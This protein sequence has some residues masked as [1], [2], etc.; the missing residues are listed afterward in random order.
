M[1]I[2]VSHLIY[3][4]F[5]ILILSH[6]IHFEGQLIK[7]QLWKLIESFNKYMMRTHYM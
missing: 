7:I 4:Y 5:Q 3:N 1:F 6:G 2:F